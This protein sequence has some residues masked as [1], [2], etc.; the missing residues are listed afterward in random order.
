MCRARRR[1]GL[2]VDDEKPMRANVRDDAIELFLRIVVF[3]LVVL[4]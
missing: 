3:K 2:G 4:V 1:V